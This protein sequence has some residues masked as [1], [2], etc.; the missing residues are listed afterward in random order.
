MPSISSNLFLSSSDYYYSSD[1]SVAANSFGMIIKFTSAAAGDCIQVGG[2]LS[3]CQH[4][5][6]WPT[7]TWGTAGSGEFSATISVADADYSWPTGNYTV[8]F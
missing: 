8:G 6:A 1:P 2:G 4:L 7:A 3:V 5:Y